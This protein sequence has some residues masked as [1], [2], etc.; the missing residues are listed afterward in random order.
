MIFV[1][2]AIFFP[3]LSFLLLLFNKNLFSKKIIYFI[4]NFFVFLSF[5]CVIKTTFLLYYHPQTL[6]IPLWSWIKCDLFNIQFNFI[7]N[8]KSILLLDMVTFIGFL[9][10]F[11]SIWYMEKNDDISRYFA[12]IN[13]FIMWIEILILSDNLLL[14]FFSWE[15]AGLCSYLLIGFYKKKIE[16]GYSAL[17]SFL[18][19][20][21]T[22]S[23]LLIAMFL[24][25]QRYHTLN[26][27]KLKN[28]VFYNSLILKNHFYNHIISFFLLLG[29]IGKSA[30]IPVH[31]WL[32]DAM[33]GPTP[34]SAL[35]HAATMVTLG[36]Y[37]IIKTYYFFLLSPIILKFLI[38][39]G[40][41]TL[42]I[43]SFTAIFQSDLKKILA[44][45]TMSQMGYL[46]LSLGIKNIHAAFL[47]LLSHS[48][49]KA[50]LFLASGSLIKNLNYER[51]I[52]KINVSY[53][54]FKIIFFSFF[55]GCLSL[56]SF[57]FIT[58][59][60]YSKE[61]IFVSLLKSNHFFVLSLAMLGTFFTSI[62]TF[63]VFFYIFNFSVF[64]S[65]YIKKNDILQN[66]S[67]II[68]SISCLPV[69][70]FGIQKF[71]NFSSISMIINEISWK[72]SIFTFL[73]SMLGGIFLYMFKKFF[74]DICFFYR[75]KN[76]IKFFQ[77]VIKKD[78]YFN[79]LYKKLFCLFFF[80]YIQFFKKNYLENFFDIFSILIKFLS[81]WK[82]LENKKKFS[83]Y[84]S[85]IIIINIIILLM[86]IYF[87]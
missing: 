14:M 30:Q 46:F 62:Y 81:N 29:A 35:F 44:Y 8:K 47:H 48:F 79:K 24:I 26:F 52:F 72:M 22:D 74:Q 9:I 85:I 7:I 66:F 70:Y 77:K 31:I 33:V 23:F 3:F 50:L 10:N 56:L 32:L 54:N 41:F 36:I 58:S 12:Y 65:K 55:V 28:V 25:I 84:F 76:F 61:Q 67:L 19:T 53:K 2:L 18:I 87:F 51:N 21:F 78:W 42:I 34:I 37:L 11:F 38:W 71:Y 4:G 17:K 57:P 82:L 40:V 43:S 1:N 5:L 80:N 68:L 45:S 64:D 15:G 86:C 27:L 73:I 60:F 20:R 49:F 83:W 75:R 59:S 39:I 63:R 6:I 16:N 13:L 69:T